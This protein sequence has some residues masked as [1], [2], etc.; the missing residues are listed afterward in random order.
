MNK[1]KNQR[2]TAILLLCLLLASAFCA[3]TAGVVV[4]NPQDLPGGFEDLTGDRIVLNVSEKRIAVDERFALVAAI[5]PLPEYTPAFSY[6]TSNDKVATVSGEG[7]IKGIGQGSCV[8]TVSTGEGGLRA[9]CLV[10]VFDGEP[11]DPSLSPSVSPDPSEEPTP[12]PP[13]EEPTPTPP[14]EEPTPSDDDPPEEIIPVEGIELIGPT[15]A[16]IGKTY[17][18]TVK[19][20]PENANEKLYFVNSNGRDATM[21][22]DGKLTPLKKGR[23]VVTVET[24]D[25]R[26]SDSITVELLNHVT[27]LA[28][29]HIDGVPYADAV[30]TIQVGQTVT[31]TASVLPEGTVHNGVYFVNERKANVKILAGSSDIGS[32]TIKQNGMDLAVTGESTGWIAITIGSQDFTSMTRSY[33]FKIVPDT[34]PKLTL[35][36]S[37]MEVHLGQSAKLKATLSNC[38]GTL[39]FESSD[40]TVLKVEQD[41]TLQP[42]AQG[43]ATVT[44]TLEEKGLKA[45]CAV[46]VLAPLPSIELEKDAITLEVGESA[47]AG[48]TLLHGEGSLV[49]ETDAE[50]I[51]QIDADGTIHAL[52]AGSV[53]VTVKSEDGSLSA[54]IEV[55]VNEKEPPLPDEGGDDL[56]DDGGQEPDEGGGEGG[57]DDGGEPSDDQNDLSAQQ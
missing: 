36:Q 17:Q 40:E 26:L 10:T 56:P 34:T 6:A 48:A 44:V 7:V 14:S 25:G 45:E 2:K 11:I 37:S 27:G 39:L 22:S 12:T 13:S 4:K 8:I 46:S 52:S 5:V 35:D 51:V 32:A 30:K 3:C 9:E 19:V 23:T 18:Y 50:G 38:S 29:S 41:G 24:A 33:V 42:V 20:T 15:D 16:F 43:S 21:T 1:R 53:T 47:S 28:F 49:Y 54:T 31:L 55:T 57:E